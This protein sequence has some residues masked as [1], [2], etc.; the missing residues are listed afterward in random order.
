MN[1]I[2]QLVTTQAPPIQFFDRVEIVKGPSSAGFEWASPV[3]SSITSRKRPPGLIRP[4][5]VLGSGLFQLQIQL[6]SQGV[7]PNLSKLSYRLNVLWTREITKSRS[8]IIRVRRPALVEVPST[9]PTRTAQLITGTQTLSRRADNNLS[10]IWEQSTL[11]TGA[12]FD[13]R[14]LSALPHAPQSGKQHPGLGKGATLFSKS[15]NSQS[16]LGRLSESIVQHDIP[17][18]SQL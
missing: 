1:G 16:S 9:M 17:A 4:S 2:A 18:R 13:G 14:Q 11:Y 7:A 6:D 10:A 5:S 12:Q 15:F 3:V 8:G